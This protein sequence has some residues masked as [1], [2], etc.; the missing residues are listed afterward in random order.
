MGKQKARGYIFITYKACHRPYHVHIF[1]G[2]KYL[3]KFDIEN[4]K[5]E[6]KNLVISKTGKLAK[7]LRELGYL[8]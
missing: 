7:A 6:T 1:K 3:G 2:S 5:A 8:I 4:Q